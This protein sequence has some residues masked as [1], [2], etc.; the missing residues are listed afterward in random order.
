MY[1]VDTN[2]FLRYLTNDDPS[3]AAK[4]RELL[5]QA[6]AKRVELATN[7]AIIAE[8]VYVLS[9]KKQNGYGLERG[10]IRE[11][12]YP[13]VLIRGLKLTNRKG[14]LRA[15]DIFAETELDFEDAL[16]IAYAETRKSRLVYSYDTGID[17]VSSVERR[18]P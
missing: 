14:V 13:L 1:F 5:K 9:S 18:E 3:K 7:D 2:I 10:R 11:L 12:L 17:A 8:M 16:L 6:D 15:L 4:C